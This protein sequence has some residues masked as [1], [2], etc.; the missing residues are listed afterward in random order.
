[1]KR[2]KLQMV[3]FVNGCTV[4]ATRPNSL[5]ADVHNRM[6]VIIPRRQEALCLDCSVTHLDLLQPFNEKL[7]KVYPLPL[8]SI[9]S[10]V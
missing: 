10:N 1:M 4:I 3:D 2:G 6:P 9:V 5:P 8:S 7:M